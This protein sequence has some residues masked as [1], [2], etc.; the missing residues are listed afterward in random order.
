MKSEPR[1][2]AGVNLRLQCKAGLTGRAQLAMAQVEFEIRQKL[3]EQLSAFLTPRMGLFRSFHSSL[4]PLT[5]PTA[6]LRL[7]RNGGTPR[8]AAQSAGSKILMG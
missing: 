6:I 8:C 7:A 4:Y 2:T 5:V 1:L 3:V